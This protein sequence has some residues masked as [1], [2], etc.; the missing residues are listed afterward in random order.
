[1][2]NILLYVPLPGPKFKIWPIDLTL[3]LCFH[4]KWSGTRNRCSVSN[5][6]IYW[7]CIFAFRQQAPQRGKEP[8]GV[9]LKWSS[10]RDYRVCSS[11]GLMLSLLPLHII[12]NI[13][14]PLPHVWGDKPD[15]C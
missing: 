15:L 1:M 8:K 4:L 5:L 7:K 3:V 9:C 10:G 12:K 11:D 2:F 6:N 13:V 14:F